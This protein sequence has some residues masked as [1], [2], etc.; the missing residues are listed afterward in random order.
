MIVVAFIDI[1]NGQYHLVLVLDQLVKQ[2]HVIGV[3][4]VV[5]SKHIHLIHQIL[6]SL[7]QW[8]LRPLEIGAEGLRQCS[9]LKGELNIGYDAIDVGVEDL[10]HVNV[11]FENQSLDNARSLLV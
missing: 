8:A 9:Q 5:T 11:F 4:E 7:W 10:L 3:L 1:E 2:L 6:L